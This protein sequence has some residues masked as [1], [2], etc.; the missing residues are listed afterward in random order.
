MK[1]GELARKTGLSVRA[2]HHYDEIGLLSPSRRTAEGH[3][4][5]GKGEVERLQRIVSLRHIGL[6][7]DEIRECLVRPEYSLDRVLEL[8]VERIDEEVRRRKRLRDL[9][10]RLLGRLRATETISVD[11]LTQ[12]I[13]ITMN[14][15]KYYTPEQLEQL[16]RRRETLGQDRIEEVQ[17]EWQE[18]FA[19][20]AAAMNE[21]LDPASEKVQVLARKS[22]D[23]I[24]EF[25]GGDP[26]ISASL[27][28]MYKTEGAEN[29]MRGHGMQTAPGLSEYMDRARAAL[30]GDG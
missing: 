2:L 28:N 29:V 1:V 26:G 24:G 7:L 30:Q 16:E 21:G 15:E 18:L 17:R 5:Y 19:A 23:L 3:R 14:Y 25:T 4:L 8:Q 6:S 12:T 10:Q 20:Y 9:I 11:E 27:G 13:E 22:A